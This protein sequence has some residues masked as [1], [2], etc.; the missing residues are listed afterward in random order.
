MSVTLLLLYLMLVATLGRAVLVADHRGPSTCSR[1]GLPYER[2]A[3]GET[4]CR[5]G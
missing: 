4:I 3:L 5:C 2:R 1:C